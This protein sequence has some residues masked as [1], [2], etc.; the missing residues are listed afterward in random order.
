MLVT[1]EGSLLHFDKEGERFSY[2]FKDDSF[3]NSK[4]RVVKYPQNFFRGFN[5]KIGFSFFKIKHFIG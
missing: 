2:N 4:G 5:I 3:I 1:K